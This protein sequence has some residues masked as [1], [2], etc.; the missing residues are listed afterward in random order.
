MPLI[1]QYSNDH[2]HPMSLMAD[3]DKTQN[4]RMTGI[5]TRGGG[6]EHS[7]QITFIHSQHRYIEI[8]NRLSL[9]Q[10][11][12]YESFYR[13]SPQAK[14]LVSEFI[15]LWITWGARYGN[16]G[17]KKKH[18]RFVKGRINFIWRSSLLVLLLLKVFKLC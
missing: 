8:I 9:L 11:G 1:G 6:G 18:T 12:Q 3:N 7:L 17:H 4:I 2:A 15:G 16:D 14:N 5:V 13:I 10:P